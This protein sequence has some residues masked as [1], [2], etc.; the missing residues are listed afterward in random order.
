MRGKDSE[1][2]YLCVHA[3]AGVKMSV[4]VHMGECIKGSENV[5]MD[6]LGLVDFCMHV[7]ACVSVKM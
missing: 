2:V 6:S 7:Q 1:C 5:S 4:R 3:G